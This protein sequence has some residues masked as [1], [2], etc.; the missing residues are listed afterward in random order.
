[1]RPLFH[2]ANHDHR[3][4]KIR[5]G[6]AGGMRQRHKHLSTATPMLAD[7]IFARRVAALE[8]LF[9]PQP[10]KNALGR[11][12]LFARMLEIVLQSLINE[13]DEAIKFRPLDLSRSSIPGRDRKAHHLLNPRATSRNGSQ[14]CTH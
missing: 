14:P 7:V 11:V 2:T 3:L 10:F 8:V 13:A 5:L 12:T 1:M 6:V 9:V 4:A